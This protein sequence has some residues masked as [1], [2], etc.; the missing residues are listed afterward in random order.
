MTTKTKP[1]AVLVLALCAALGVSTFISAEDAVAEAKLKTPNVTTVKAISQ[2]QSASQDE[3]QPVAVQKPAA[4][5][6][7]FTEAAQP[8]EI[9]S[10]NKS[11]SAA[12]QSAEFAPGKALT[13][14]FD[15]DTEG[16]TKL[17][18]TLM[19]NIY[20]GKET[21]W[22]KDGI[23]FQNKENRLPKQANGYYREYTI[24]PKGRQHDAYTISLGGKQYTVGVL[25]SARGP[26]RIITG[27]TKEIFYTPD[28]YT[29]FVKLTIVR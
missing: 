17:V 26:E 8:E 25:Q 23:T 14:A 11:V 16:R 1:F 13:P 27:G 9:T 7:S 19:S 28:H 6:V 12:V 3:T 22:P 18:L 2:L 20:N 24:V 21:G 29:T 4:P 10:S 5:S 15:N